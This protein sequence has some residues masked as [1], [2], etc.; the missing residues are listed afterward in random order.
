MTSCLGDMNNTQNAEKGGTF[1]PR[2][3][4]AGTLDGRAFCLK[5]VRVESVAGGAAMR[6]V[7][8]WADSVRDKDHN[9]QW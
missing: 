9:P 1:S 2:V 6:A 7:K 5:P 8:L 3:S 4:P